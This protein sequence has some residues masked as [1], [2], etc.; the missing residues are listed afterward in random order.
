MLTIRAAQ[1]KVF[2]ADALRRFEDEMVAHCKTSTIRARLC[3]VIGDDQL[4]VAIRQGMARAG[5]HGFTYR[6]PI[7][8]YIEL[9]F[10]YG[11]DFATD[12]QY[13]A[14]SRILNGP[15]DQMDRAERIHQSVLDYEEAVYG[16]GAV[17]VRKA[18]EALLLMAK[19]PVTLSEADFASGVLQEMTQVF[20]QKAAYIGEEAL[21]ALIREARNDAKT[22]RFPTIRDEVLMVA[23]KFGFGHGCTNDP[24][25]PWISRTLTDEKIT[26]PAARMARLERKAVTWLEH[27]LARP[28]DGAQT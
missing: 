7:R 4:R 3:K 24:L 27:V 20:P 13:P 2:D 5:T 25:Y 16:P 1:M 19:R 8:L 21:N 9:M 14:F 11:S 22:H 10:L 28:P 12:P 17:N 23:L 15:G 6:G 18:L 26:R